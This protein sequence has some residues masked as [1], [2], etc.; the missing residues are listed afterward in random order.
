MGKYSLFPIPGCA[1]F[2]GQGMRQGHGHKSCRSEL[3][4]HDFS[5]AQP[6]ASPGWDKASS[7]CPAPS[8]IPGM[9]IP[10]H[11]PPLC[12]QTPLQCP[13]DPQDQPPGAA[14]VFL[15][16]GGAGRLE[17]APDP[18][19]HFPKQTP[20]VPAFAQ[21]TRPPPAPRRHRPQAQP[22]MCRQ[23]S[24]PKIPSVA[25]PSWNNCDGV[26]RSHVE[27]SSSSSW[28]EFGGLRAA[29]GAP[30]SPQTPLSCPF[31]V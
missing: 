9:S 18:G 29:W 8:S 16:L 22:G 23:S 3:S 19:R 30:A 28:A 26:T 10:K 6:G 15:P 1:P 4:A 31:A 14:L 7:H 24:V 5:S 11:E 12:L 2:T 20:S 17:P 25:P 13:R 27:P 21:G